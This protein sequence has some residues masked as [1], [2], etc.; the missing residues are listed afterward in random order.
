MDGLDFEWDGRKS[1]EN[2]RKHGVCFDEARTVFLD[3]NAILYDDP[4]HSVA[5]DRFLLL[6]MSERLRTLVVCHCYRSE[7]TV[8][9]ILSARKASAGEARAYWR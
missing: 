7:D 2:Q 3:E 5:E 8:I 1:R 6:G 9:R 4:E